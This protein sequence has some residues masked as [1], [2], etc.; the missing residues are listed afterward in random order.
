[1]L[2]H[3]WLG[4]R[5]SIWP[6]KKLSDEVLAWISVCS[7]VQMEKKAVIQMSVCSLFTG[8]ACPNQQ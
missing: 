6:V 4:D 1:V 7:K 8:R 5:N 3:C 2:R